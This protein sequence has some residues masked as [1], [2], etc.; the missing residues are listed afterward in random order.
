MRSTSTRDRTQ[1]TDAA[2]AELSRRRLLLAIAGIPF[3]APLAWALTG[4]SR[5]EE[6]AARSGPEPGAAQTAPLPSPEAPAAPHTP[7]EPPGAPPGGESAAGGATGRPGTDAL[8][9][10]IAAMKPTVQAL[11]YVSASTRPDQHCA[12]CQFFTMRSTD[13]GTCQLFTQGF[14]AAGGWCASWTK[15]AD[16]A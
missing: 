10:E 13:R 7:A 5:S 9:T 15:R 11:Q 16:G 12:N 4:C 8:V 2:G 1:T 14:V 3:A 6:P